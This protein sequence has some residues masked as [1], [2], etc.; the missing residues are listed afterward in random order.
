M[1]NEK[2]TLKSSTFATPCSTR[3]TSKIAKQFL[4]E[5]INF[6]QYQPTARRIGFK[7]D[8]PQ[9]WVIALEEYITTNNNLSTEWRV[10]GHPGPIEQV[11]APIKITGINKICTVEIHIT[12]GNLFFHGEWAPR[13][14]SLTY[15]HDKKHYRELPQKPP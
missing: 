11:F 13:L 3:S 4:Y 8:R 9:Q 2:P 5:Q 12:T 1:A 6:G 7:T 15:A 14:C 10:V